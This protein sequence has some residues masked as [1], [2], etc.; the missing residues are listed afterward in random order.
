M[1]AIDIKEKLYDVARLFFPKI[2]IVW[3]EQTNTKPEIPYLMLRLGDI[4]RRAF[5]V[6]DDDV[7]RCYHCS[8]VAE[9]QLYTN[10]MTISAAKSATT[11]YVNTATSDLMDFANFME[12]EAVLDLLSDPGI[13]M[14]LMP[15]VRDLSSLENDRKYRYRAMAE[16]TVT[17]VEKANGWYGIGGMPVIPN[18]SGGGTG[19]MASTPCPEMEDVELEGDITQ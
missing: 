18:S 3:A 6:E 17:F 13:E 19:D 16:F 7:G 1:N 2:D 11:N 14:S 8:T 5:P 4:N 10:G 9:V 15:P 12:S